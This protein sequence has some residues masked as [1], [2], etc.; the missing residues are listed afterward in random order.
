MAV[1]A[2]SYGTA[3]GVAAFV[4]R[5]AASTGDAA[6]F[7]G[8]TVPTLAQVEGYIDAISGMLNAMLAEA[9]FTVP[10]TDAD[11]T[12]MLAF[13]VNEEVAAI[14]DGIHGSG[15][16]GPSTK[17]GGGKGRFAIIL[18][19][20]KSFVEGNKAGL[21]RLGA[22]RST[23]QTSGIGYRDT[24]ESGDATHPIFQRKAFGNAFKNWDAES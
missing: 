19:D 11:L 16:F 24:D 1:A 13:F 5:W 7:T 6:T 12:P 4:P 14:A 17:T 21:E 8:G 18:D 2:H 23:D 22:A 10:V 3:V 20:V 15:R 9:G